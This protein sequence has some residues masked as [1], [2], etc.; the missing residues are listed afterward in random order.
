MVV[1]FTQASEVRLPH[2]PEINWIY[3][4]EKFDPIPLK[5]IVG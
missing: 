2:T 1:A 4:E 5:V 3:L